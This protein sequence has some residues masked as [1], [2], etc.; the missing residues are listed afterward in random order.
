[1]D[2]E[3]EFIIEIF[4]EGCVIKLPVQGK[5][6]YLKEKTFLGDLTG[7]TFAPALL[8]RPIPDPKFDFYHLTHDQYEQYLEFRRALRAA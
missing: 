8:P 6:R 7:L 5:E 3:Q 4:Y 2:R 1:M